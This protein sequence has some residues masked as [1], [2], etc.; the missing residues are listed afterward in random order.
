MQYTVTVELDRADHEAVLERLGA[1]ERYEPVVHAAPDRRVTVTMTTD[2]TLG[3]AVSD[4]LQLLTSAG[5]DPYAVQ[6]LPSEEW[7]V[8]AGAPEMLSLMNVADAAAE[9]GVSGQRVR[10]MLH[11]DVRQ[12]V[13]VK[14]GRDW[15]VSRAS[16]QARRADL[17]VGNGH[18]VRGP[19]RTRT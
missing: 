8:R 13:G 18:P 6:A 19:L 15:L 11:P 10:Q 16:V 12:L 17:A 1:Y 5:L 9:L 3:R 7:A 14:V 2:S 4:A